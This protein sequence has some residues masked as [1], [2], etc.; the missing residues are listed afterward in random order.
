MIEKVPKK[1]KSIIVYFVLTYLIILSIW[2][3]LVGLVEILGVGAIFG[4]LITLLFWAY[5]TPLKFIM[6][7]LEIPPPSFLSPLSDEPIGI[8]VWIGIHLFNITMIVAVL[9]VCYVV[10]S[11]L[12]KQ[13]PNKGEKGVN[14]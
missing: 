1:L 5:I 14:H 9:I 12:K 10:F 2:I 8:F 11:V 13:S 3:F 6:Q 7:G 4:L